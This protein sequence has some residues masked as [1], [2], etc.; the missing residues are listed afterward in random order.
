MTQFDDWLQQATRQ[1]SKESA[2]LVRAEIHDH[3]ELALEAAIAGGAS[4]AQAARTAFAALGDAR[5]AN[6]QYREVLLTSAEARVLR[7]SKWEAKNI[8]ARPWLKQ[9]LA[10][11][12]VAMLCA[13]AALYFSGAALLARVFFM[14][15]VGTWLLFAVPFLPVYTPSR[16]RAVRLVK[17]AVIIGA[18]AL[19]F[20]SRS[21]NASW[22]LFS[23]LWPM[24]WIEWTRFSIRRK[25]P[26]ANW[27]K[28]LYL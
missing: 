4:T 13:A 18:F 7:E 2:A 11:V 27:P 28:H 14:G 10:A 12:P 1:L 26:V 17:W 20:G 16:A 24:A 23:C 9:L 6:C 22:L 5:A 19:A 3:Y 8:C 25:L 15:A 21:T